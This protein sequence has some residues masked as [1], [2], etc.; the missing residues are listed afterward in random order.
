MPNIARISALPAS[1]AAVPNTVGAQ[2]D[3]PRIS[4]IR[5]SLTWPYPCPPSSGLEVAGPEALCLHFVLQ[6]RQNAAGRGVGRVV[7]LTDMWEQ[8]IKV[9][10]L[11]ADKGI[12]PVELL[13]GSGSVSKSHMR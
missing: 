8:Q 6:W 4:F 13:L 7:R 3:R 11:L 1:G 2:V 5:A 10:A 12:H 9:F